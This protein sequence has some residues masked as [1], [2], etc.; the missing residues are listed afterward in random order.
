VRSS[1]NACQK[2]KKSW[3]LHDCF[4]YGLLGL[5][6]AHV[7]LSMFRRL[8]LVALAISILSQRANLAATSI[9]RGNV[10]PRRLSEEQAR[11]LATYAPI[12]QYPFEARAKHLQGAAWCVW[13]WTEEL[14]M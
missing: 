10:D 5:D 9:K 1:Q 13:M 8:T 14:G 4:N 6:M 7:F 2:G 11:A 12:P 3:F